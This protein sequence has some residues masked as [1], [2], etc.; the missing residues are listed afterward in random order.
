MCFV[1]RLLAYRNTIGGRILFIM[2][3]YTMGYFL[4][5]SGVIAVALFL[6]WLSRRDVGDKG[7][8]G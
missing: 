4:V 1:I 6:V 3:D 2:S 8:E 5:A 7:A